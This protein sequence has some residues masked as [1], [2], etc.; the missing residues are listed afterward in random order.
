VSLVTEVL[1]CLHGDV[2]SVII[3]PAAPHRCP[4]VRVIREEAIEGETTP[5]GTRDRGVVPEHS[6]RL[7][8]TALITLVEDILGN[9]E[10]GAVKDDGVGGGGELVRTVV[11][12]VELGGWSLRVHVGEAGIPKL[13]VPVQQ[14]V[15]GTSR[16]QES[17]SHLGV[18]GGTKVPVVGGLGPSAIRGDG[19]DAVAQS[20]VYGLAKEVFGGSGGI[21]TEDSKSAKGKTTVANAIPVTRDV[22]LPP[23]EVD[24][25]S[26][27]DGLARS[28]AVE[29]HVI[30]HLL[31][32]FVFQD[33]MKP[34]VTNGIG[35]NHLSGIQKVFVVP[36]VSRRTEV[37]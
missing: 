34:I 12:V 21:V 28:Q 5:P 8:R 36:F 20:V 31:L 18:T 13:G 33:I 27:K 2:E 32:L 37:A 3:G 35:G 14:T 19:V 29:D 15:M 7:S 6:P 24:R 4:L 17:R 25:G 22:G 16:G 23:S 26:I 9:F 11:T 10:L 1:A 30:P